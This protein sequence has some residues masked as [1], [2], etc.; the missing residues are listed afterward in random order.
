MISL[1]GKKA[2]EIICLLFVLMFMLYSVISSGQIQ[3]TVHDS[4]NQPL[5][6]ANVLLINQKDSSLITGVMVSDVGTFSIQNFK[7]GKYLI[8]ATMIGYKTTLSQPFEIKSS[9]DHFHVNP[10]I[11]EEDSKL[12]SSVDVVA[13]KPIYEQ[14]IDRMVVNVEPSC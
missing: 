13:K 2:N 10:I 7:P 11:A 6:F 12:I 14:K 4:N 8:K 9:N 3:G 1:Y 5:T